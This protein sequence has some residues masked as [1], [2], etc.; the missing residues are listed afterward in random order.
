MNHNLLMLRD[1]IAAILDVFASG[2]ISQ[3]VQ[4][5]RRMLEDINVALEKENLQ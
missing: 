5:L 2:Q 3:G 1:Q 4:M